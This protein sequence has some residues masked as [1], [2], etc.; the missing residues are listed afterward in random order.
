[1]RPKYTRYLR[2]PG[3]EQLMA[4]HRKRGKTDRPRP[5][6]PASLSALSICAQADLHGLECEVIELLL[7]GG[8]KVVRHPCARSLDLAHYE[9]TAQ[10]VLSSVSLVGDGLRLSR[11]LEPSGVILGFGWRS[12]TTAHSL[13]RATG[14]PLLMSRLLSP[15][16][17]AKPISCWFPTAQRRM[18]SPADTACHVAGSA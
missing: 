1:M 17:A 8:W 14:Y 13:R 11:Q 4:R 5:G 12:A 18:R 15:G 16:R 6:S 10:A 3:A 9:G 2:K 7:S